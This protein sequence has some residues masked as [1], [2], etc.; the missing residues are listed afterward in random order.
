MA[1]ADVSA[2]DLKKQDKT[3]TMTVSAEQIIVTVAYPFAGHG[4]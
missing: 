1:H 2:D 4:E 3:V